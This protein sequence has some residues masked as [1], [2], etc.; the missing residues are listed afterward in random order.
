MA[1]GKVPYWV[2]QR[3]I[4]STKRRGEIGCPLLSDA[5]EELS[6]DDG[7]T[8]MKVIYKSAQVI[9]KLIL[10]FTNKDKPATALRISSNMDDVPAELYTIIRSIMVG[11]VQD[12]ENEKRTSNLDRNALTVSQN[13]MFEFKSNRRVKHK[14]SSDRPQRVRE[15]P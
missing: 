9:R 1:E 11:P 10:D 6:D 13:I 3:E 2:A 15:N 8:H 4:C 12:L 7:V 5:C 14:P